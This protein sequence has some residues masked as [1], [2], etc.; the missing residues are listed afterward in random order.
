M[1]KEF[2]NTAAHELRTPIQPII[3]ITAILNDEIQSK[4]HKEFL[5]VLLRNV[6]RLKLLSEDILDVTKIEGD[7]LILN[8][9]PFTIMKI[10]IDIIENYKNEATIKNIT[11]ECLFSEANQDFVV[12]EDKEK[13][14]QVISN[15][16]NNSI[17]FN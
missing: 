16:I 10:I 17:K 9:E 1:Q 8:K 12:Y 15:L 2:I 5:E 14:N 3:G 7:S 6:R 13:I 4:R 11:F